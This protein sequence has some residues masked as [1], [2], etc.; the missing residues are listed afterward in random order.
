M[1]HRALRFDPRIVRGAGRAVIGV[2]LRA[3]L[4]AAN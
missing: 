4:A 1:N 2:G 3:A